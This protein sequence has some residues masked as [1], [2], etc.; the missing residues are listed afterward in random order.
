MLTSCFFLAAILGARVIFGAIL[1]S[2]TVLFDTWA[3]GGRY[4]C[5]LFEELNRGKTGF[6]VKNDSGPNWPNSDFCCST[7]SILLDQP[8][9]IYD[10]L[11]TNLSNTLR[12]NQGEVSLYQLQIL[13]CW[14][15]H[16]LHSCYIHP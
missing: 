9:Q 7:S 13:R 11:A 3:A 1:N 6:L 16:T 5:C 15:R 12:Q 10:E 4:T 14:Y 8:V 2:A